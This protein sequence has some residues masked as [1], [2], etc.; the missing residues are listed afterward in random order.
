MLLCIDQLLPQGGHVGV[1]EVELLGEVS[2][3]LGPD[4]LL[5]HGRDGGGSSA[6]K[7]EFLGQFGVLP[8]RAKLLAHLGDGDVVAPTPY[9]ELFAQAGELLGLDQLLAERGRVPV[10]EVELLAQARV[11][12]VDACQLPPQLL[13]GPLELL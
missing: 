5:A 1:G 11:R 13:D 7:A 4:K 9:L 6:P 8:G 12:P 3:P 10:L 2:A